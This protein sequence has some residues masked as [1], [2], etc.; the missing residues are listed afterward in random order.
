MSYSPAQIYFLRRKKT[1]P[2]GLLASSSAT[3]APYLGP[4]AGRTFIPN[5]DGTST[6]PWV[7]AETSHILKDDVSGQIEIWW[8]NFR[9]NSGASGRTDTALGSAATA[10]AQITYT[11]PTLG[12]QTVNLLDKS[13]GTTA[14]TAADG[15]WFKAVATITALAGTRIKPRIRA[16]FPNGMPYSQW[17]ADITN[18]DLFQFGASVPALTTTPT[19]SFASN[20][21]LYAPCAILAMTTKPTMYINGDSRNQGLGDRPNDTRGHIGQFA[22]LFG[23]HMAYINVSVA[24]E[25]ADYF[26]DPVKNARRRELAAFCT[27]HALGLGFNDVVRLG[28][29]P[30][31]LQTALNS[32]RDSIGK[33]TFLSTL[34][35]A[36][37]SGSVNTADNAENTDRLAH[38]AWAKAVPA[39]YLGCFDPAGVLESPSTPGTWASLSYVSSDGTHESNIGNGVAELTG[40]PLITSAGVTVAPLTSITVGDGTIYGVDTAQKDY[41]VRYDAAADALRF[42]LRSGDIISVPGTERSE[43]TGFSNPVAIGNVIAGSFRLTVLP[44]AANTAAWLTL[45]QMHQINNVGSTSGSNPFGIELAAERLRVVTK[46]GNPSSPTYTNQWTSSTDIVRG[47]EYLITFEVNFHPS[48]GYLKVSVDGTQVVNI[49]GA[50]CFTDTASTYWKQGIYRDPAP[51]TMSAIVRGAAV[52]RRF[53]P[54]DLG[55]AL[56]ATWL[57]GADSSS[58]TIATGVSQWSD[59]SGN[60]KHATQATGSAQP[61]Y[62][63][64][65]VT[66]SA[67]TYLASSLSA[68]NNSESAFAV[69]N[70]PNLTGAR[71]I[72]G[73]SAAA[74]REFRIDGTTGVLR[75]NRFSTTVQA[76]TEGAPTVA[77]G[78]DHIVGVVMSQSGTNTFVVDGTTGTATGAGGA[79]AAS[80]TQF[81]RNTGGADSATMTVKEIIVLS[82]NPTLSQ[83]QKI[84]GYLAWKWGLQANLPGAHPYKSIAP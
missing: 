57:D 41:S 79:F 18:G 48:S 73:T 56:L 68:A 50:T 39:G 23:P 80:T 29:T 7:L 75:V 21:A 58:V 34:D 38:N 36:T 77:A 46:T 40:L 27:H 3:V 33:P 53:S 72:L 42:E 81:G 61:S 6:N 84:E 14:L 12:S 10:T 8:A 4:V 19:N 67:T 16:N 52:A 31:Q 54:T 59:K 69:V 47:R 60:A 70:L 63:S 2:G 17:Q 5:E 43:I 26:A 37:T 20:L 65:A 55:S 9:A 30:A 1:R 28:K 82:A 15:G 32:I 25:T 64:S 78:A 45:A 22:R 11:H 74:G 71:A 62:A 49:T 24:G 83:R 76:S 66:F 44:G 35:P 51:E 13:G